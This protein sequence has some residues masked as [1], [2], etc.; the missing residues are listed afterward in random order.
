MLVAWINGR[1]PRSEVVA[2]RIVSRGV[3]ATRQPLN[4]VPRLWLLLEQRKKRVR[5]NRHLIASFGSPL[6]CRRQFGALP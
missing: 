5:S 6:F 2:C 4:S 1:A 3:L